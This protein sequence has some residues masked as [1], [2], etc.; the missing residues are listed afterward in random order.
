MNLDFTVQSAVVFVLLAG[1]LAV[2]LLPPRNKWSWLRFI[3]YILVFTALMEPSVV[4]KEENKDQPVVGIFLDT[5]GSMEPGN[6]FQKILED[7]RR[8][9]DSL[10]DISRVK[11]YEFSDKARETDFKSLET[12]VNLSREKS[13]NLEN[14]VKEKKLDSR[15]I[16]TDGRYN[17]GKSPLVL[18]RLTYS[19]VFPVGV[20]ID[21]KIPNLEITDFKNPGFGFRGDDIRIEFNLLNMSRSM[22]NTV[23][24]IEGPRG[25]AA[26]KN[27]ELKGRKEIP[28]AMDISSDKIGLSEY[29]LTVE[30][31]EGERST[32]NNTRNF[33][34]T[35]KRKKIRVLYVAGT[36]STEYAFFR[37]LV[38]SDPYIDL[39]TFLI[40]RNPDNVTIVPERELSLI[41]FPAREMFTRKIYD[42]DL[43]IYDNFK[44]SRFFPA[45]YLEHIKKFV[46]QGGGF[47]MTGGK[48]S[49]GRGDYRGTPIQELLPVG[50]GNRN[51]KWV[52][53]KFRPV[54]KESIGHPVLDLAGDE[55]ISR[56]VW[57]EMPE[58]EGY[59]NSLS[60]KEE[61]TVLIEN[62]RGNP[63]LTVGERGQG[64]TMALNANTTWRWCLG[65]S[66]QGKTPYYYNQFWHNVIRFMIK[67]GGQDKVRIFPGRKTV[68][69]GENIKLN[70]NVVDKYWEPLDGA[71]I[72]LEIKSPSGKT[73]PPGKIESTSEKGWYK[74]SVPVEE[75]GTYEIEA[76][77]YKDGR[78][79]GKNKETF[80][81]KYI[82]KEMIN[83]SLNSELL[84]T[85]A[86]KS[87]GEYFIAGN[88]N[89][90]KIRANLNQIHAEKQDVIMR[91]EWYEL[92]VYI[93]FMLIILGEW[94]LRRQAGLS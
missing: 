57:R 85:M 42:F 52:V 15:I 33:P 18:N 70:I 90:D 71:R 31:L 19:P 68:S 92:P 25:I 61:S 64:R 77:A 11:V 14:V 45:G 76:R 48:N 78:L 72:R 69:L 36:P 16:L 83:L 7:A 53:E 94:L 58:L 21:R 86:E 23:A 24:Y 13:T 89:T 20:D 34:L 54:I 4:L 5:S 32:I 3:G 9:K 66:G 35:V 38:K 46:L 28:V 55:K 59:D 56:N 44:Y 60:P 2:N 26:R 80:R 81:G 10:S 73:I 87:G 91:Y 79:L 47:I 75:S 51:S 27:I 39:T 67:S 37:R 63:I 65:L 82:D 29:K 49:F 22:E 88:V 74:A 12:K 8:I 30:A 93:L 17:E 41:Q 6:K 40:L 50:L 43:L 62:N 1:G 84:R